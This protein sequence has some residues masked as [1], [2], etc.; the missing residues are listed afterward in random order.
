MARLLSGGKLRVGGSGE[1][2][3]LQ[4]AMPQLPANDDTST[5]YTIVTNNVLQTS[6][7]NSLGNLEHYQ[8]EIWSNLPDGLIK[9]TGTGTGFVY[10]TQPT[11]STSTDSGALVVKGGVGIGGTIWTEEDIHVNKLTIGQGYKGINNI[12]IRG[13]PVED[14]NEEYDFPEGKNS[15]AIG[16]GSLLG[17]QTSV[18]S[19]AIGRYSLNSGTMIANSIAIGDKALK[20]I[21]S[22][23]AIFVSTITNITTSSPAI[24]TADGHGLST[25]TKVTLVDIPGTGT[26][27]PGPYWIDIYSENEVTLFT[28][29]IL[30]TPADFG[31]FIYDGP[32]GE[33]AR[34]PQ[35]DNNIALGTDAGK[36]LID[37][38]KNFFLGD[39]V[40]K[41]LITG[42]GNVLIGHDIASTVVRG[43][44]NIAIG[45]DNLVDGIDN[46]VNIGSVFY[47]NGGGYLQLNANTGVGIGSTATDSYLA[48]YIT[49]ATQTNPVLLVVENHGLT[50]GDDIVVTEVVGMTELNDQ[51]YWVKR[52]S[53]DIIELH[54]S[55]DVASTATWVDGTGFSNYVSGGKVTE[56]RLSG[57]LTVLGGAGITENLLL[58]GNFESRGSGTNFISG[59]LLPVGTVNLG[60][61][62]S[63]FNHIYLSGTTI[64]L[65]TVTLKSEDSLSFSVESTAGYVTQTIGNAFLDSGVQ[66]TG[67]DSGSLVVTGGAGIGGDLHVGGQL[68]VNEQLILTTSSFINSVNSGDDITITDTG[69]GVLQFD[70]TSTLQSVTNRGS[71]TTNV[72]HFDAPV[73]STSTNSGAVIVGGGGL[74]VNG[75][76]YAQ[77]RVNSESL[78]ILGTTLSS[79][80]LS[81]NT[82][83]TSTLIDSYLA[84]ECRSAK[85]LIQVD[86]G[87]GTNSRMQLWESIMIVDNQGIVSYSN[88]A[89]ASNTGTGF[90]DIYPVFNV[91]EDSVEVYIATMDNSSLG[92]L[93]IKMLKTTISQ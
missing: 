14:P 30:S 90:I 10:V 71:T 17:L 12:I 8:G 27:P 18:K 86:E 72:V 62:E 53:K 39:L 60:S 16:F 6:Y 38:S 45:G 44:F 79:I 75:N 81:V 42:T 64:Y 49:S 59:D 50:S 63:K 68:Y 48:G 32:G 93:N 85:Y 82:A 61:E 11:S 20:E 67:T 36:S 66:S 56:K 46:Q 15:I 43:N 34:V 69:G 5:G 76:I 3:Y 4:N 24:V 23:Q 25:G 40:A 89:K 83:T 88:Y 70:N 26:Y 37:G 41:N 29:S 52:I 21:G 65:S 2:I 78:R 28:D 80:V 1:Y 54:S 35:L 92:E 84:N 33:L 55:P 58:L 73:E 47:Y 87:T 9:L 57:A 91:G 19:I 31:E 22:V 13:D 7:R 51:F 74:A 77:G